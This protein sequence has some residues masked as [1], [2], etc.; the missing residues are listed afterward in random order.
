MDEQVVFGGK[1]TAVRRLDSGGLGDTWEADEPR[2]PDRRGQVVQ[3]SHAPSRWRGCQQ[4]AQAAAGRHEP[5][6]R[7]R[8]RLGRAGRRRLLPRP[9]VRRRDRRGLDGR[10]RRTDAAGQGRPL[11]VRDR[12]R[13]RRV[14]RARGRAREREAR[15]RARHARRSREARRGRPAA[16]PRAGHRGHARDRDDVHEP[17]AAARGGADVPVRRV[18]CGR[19]ALRTGHGQVPLPGGR[20]VAGRPERADRHAPGARAGEPRRADARWT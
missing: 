16:H 8:A 20:R 10:G 6:R 13:A 1:Y 12:G 14:A 7:A 19:D 4:S 2:R 17:R 9:G 18:R 11:R 15:Q 5:V 3:R